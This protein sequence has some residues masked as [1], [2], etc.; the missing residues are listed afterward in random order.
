[1]NYFTIDA[2][3]DSLILENH[4]TNCLGIIAGVL[5]KQILPFTNNSSTPC[6][7]NESVRW[8][9]GGAGGHPFIFD[10]SGDWIVNNR[11]RSAASSRPTAVGARARQCESAVTG[12]G[13]CAAAAAKPGR[14]RDV[15]SRSEPARL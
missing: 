11:L 5:H 13:E 15:L 4:E 7:I 14:E 9:L 12:F 6:N 1:M 2:G 10:G 8:R 3:T